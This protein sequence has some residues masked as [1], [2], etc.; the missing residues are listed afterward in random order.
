MKKNEKPEKKSRD[1]HSS[2]EKKKDSKRYSTISKQKINLTEGNLK[3]SLVQDK[4]KNDF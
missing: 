2:N 4:K 1:S 3:I